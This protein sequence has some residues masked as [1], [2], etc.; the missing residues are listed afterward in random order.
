MATDIPRGQDPS[1]LDTD[2]ENVNITDRDRLS[3][4]TGVIG[5]PLR[6]SWPAIFAG[7]VAALALWAML[8]T[9]G[10]ALG[11]STV[12]PNDPGSLKS[13]GIFTGI[14]S[15]LSPLVAL[16]LGGM[17][18]SRGAGIVTR[19]GGAL[20]GLVMWG[21]TTLAGA[22]VLSYI[23]GA[24]ASGVASV[25]KTAVGSGAQ[26]VSGA[27]SGAGGLGSLAQTFGI[28]AD[29]ALAPINQRL[30]AEGKPT[31]TAEQLTAATKDVVQEG[32]RQGRIERELLAT[33]LAQHTALSRADAE[34]VA[35]RV[36][37]QFN[38]AKDQMSA[39]LSSAKQ[40]I[41]QGTLKAAGATGKAFW[42]VFGALFLGM[43]SAILG[44]IAGVSK[45]QRAWAGEKP[46]GTGQA[47]TP[48]REVYP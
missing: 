44:A 41:Q 29:D 25:G 34:E 4:G 22:W 1:S 31:I 37:T 19:T 46:R 24:L 18:A 27:A 45:R 16:F 11:L 43:I 9:F 42:G 7:A 2:F 39:Q 32:L 38:T 20:H 10:L 6:L 15:L 3:G 26:A 13:S 14:W 30:R 40:S 21:L 8:Y 12:D 48:H 36:E 28:N 23:V 5:A 33:N 35:G 47:A 17:V